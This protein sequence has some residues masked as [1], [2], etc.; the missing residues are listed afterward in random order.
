MGNEG[1]WLATV[2]RSRGGGV[3]LSG[4]A[5]AGVGWGQKRKRLSHLASPSPDFSLDRRVGF[6][7][8]RGVV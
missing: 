1:Q 7:S 5:R 8:A 4:L 6:F 2:H 3:G